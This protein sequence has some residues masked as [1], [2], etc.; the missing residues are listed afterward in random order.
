MQK[1]NK[2]KN[3]VGYKMLT[4]KYEHSLCNVTHH[5]LTFNI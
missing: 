3:V 5:F 4:L 2:K 1:K